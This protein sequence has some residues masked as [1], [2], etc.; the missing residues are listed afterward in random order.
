MKKGA[1]SSGRVVVSSVGR[2]RVV[3]ATGGA[4]MR[5]I[6]VVA[7]HTVGGDELAETVRERQAAE[8]CDVVLLVPAT[9][10]R[11][12]TDRFNSIGYMSSNAELGVPTPAL[13]PR[14]DPYKVARPAR[15]RLAKMREI[16]VEARGESGRSNRWTRSTTS[17]SA[18][19][20]TR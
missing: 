4:G 2:W 17:C 15:C 7:H 3:D 5:R 10:L 8:P 19:S 11:D 13:P 18:S 12:L 16:G 6:L 14:N 9:P 1:G 20:S